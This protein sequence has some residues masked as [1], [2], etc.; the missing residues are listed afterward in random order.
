MKLK[1]SVSLA[2]LLLLA[3]AARAQ[4]PAAPLEELPSVDERS[5]YGTFLAGRVAQHAGE[6]DEA[7]RRL[8]AVAG[9][10]PDNAQLRERAFIAALYAGD[11]QTAARLA[12]AANPAQPGLESLGR[13]T[14]AVDAMAG[15]DGATSVERLSSIEFPH[16][17]AAAVLRP[18]AQA[19]AGD[20]D[21]A[22]VAPESEADPIADAFSALARAQLLEMRRKHA[23]AEAVYKALMADPASAELF[24]PLYGEFLERRG[25]RADAVAVYEQGLA[26]NPNDEELKGLRERAQRRGRPGPLPSLNK[27]AAQALGYAAAAMSSYRQTELAMIYLR[28][29]MRLDPEHHQGWVLIGDALDRVRDHEAARE[30]WG[31]VPK[32]SPYYVQSRSK[33]VYSLQA[34]RQTEAALELAAEMARETPGDPRTRLTYADLLRTNGNH[35]EAV[36]LLDGL[37]G[38]GHSDWRLHYMRAVSLDK[39]N[40]WPEAE[41]ELGRAMA[42][43]PDEPEVLNYLGYAWID[44]GEKI[45]EGMALVERAV[46]GRPQSGSIQDS[47]AWAHFRL[48]EY[49]KAVELLENAVTLTPADP[50]VNDH[51]GDAYWMVGRRDEAGFQWRRVLSLNPSAELKARVEK[52]LKEGLPPPALR[53]ETTPST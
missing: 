26:A 43:S 27:G 22:L 17:T 37:I 51:L 48:G 5:A 28:L 46:A 32:G 11:I 14:Q 20:W 4:D 1:V 24:L 10:V 33:I 3:G 40:R 9:A 31:Q 25:R 7:S 19:A 23:E 39:L 6:A 35:A 42:I 45:R 50:D 49:P 13:L 2:A 47:L 30:A 16:R 12:P 18:W 38:E 34:E 29:A 52:K 8:A 36:A 53:A 44:R 15:G 21:A 41:A